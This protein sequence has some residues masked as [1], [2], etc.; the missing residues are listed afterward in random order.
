[1]NFSQFL[2]VDFSLS[3]WVISGAIL[4]FFIIQLIYYLLVYKRPYS[5]EHKRSKIQ[6]VSEN[7]PS[8]SVVIASKNESENLA[9]YL[10]SILEQDYHHF[11]VIVV[12]MGSTDETDILLK[13]FNQKYS[14]LYHTYVPAGVEDLNEKKLALTIGIKAAKNDIVLFTEA[15]CVPASEKW[16]RE[17]AIEFSKGKDIV[18]GFCKLKIGRKFAMRKFILYDNMIHGLKYLSLAILGKPFMGIGRNL[19]YRKE[20]FFE[21][22]GFSSVLNI[23][24][25]EDDLFIN[26]I[27]KKKKVGVVISPESMTQSDVVT[28]FFTWRAFKSKYLYTKKFYRGASSFILGFE[29]FSKYLFYLSVVA[30]IAYG[31][32]FSNYLLVALSVIFFIFRFIFQLNVIGNNSRLFGAG[33]YHINLFFYDIF[34]PFNNFKFRKY[35]SKRNKPKKR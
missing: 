10:P 21:E 16:I 31:V 4:L 32:L 18:L 35:A 20:I 15:Y 5:Y 2:N 26:K 33:K 13:A 14:N 3:F 9:K 19:A 34:Q 1:M 25:G 12:N 22:K 6:Q 30:G 23:D 17:F 27:S 29:T 7:L 11:E 8:I 28:N 24:G